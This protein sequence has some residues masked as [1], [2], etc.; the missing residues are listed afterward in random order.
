VKLV[1]TLVLTLTFDIV[2]F[3]SFTTDAWQGERLETPQFDCRMAARRSLIHASRSLHHFTWSNPNLPKALAPSRL[4]TSSDTTL[5][6]FPLIP[7][8]SD[9]IVASL[10]YATD[11]ELVDAI[12]ADSEP[13]APTTPSSR[14]RQPAR[15][16]SGRRY[17]SPYDLDWKSSID[18]AL[19]F[20][21]LRT[22]P[23][24]GR[25]IEHVRPRIKQIY[26]AL[27]PSG[28]HQLFASDVLIRSGDR[29]VVRDLLELDGKQPK[30]LRTSAI[31]SLYQHIQSDLAS[32]KLEALSGDANVAISKALM[33]EGNIDLVPGIWTEMCKTVEWS[34]SAS[35]DFFEIIL[36]MTRHDQLDE[37][38]KMVQKLVE[39]EVMPAAASAG[40]S[41]PNHPEARTLLVQTMITRA[42][43]EYGM[44]G[45]VQIAA[46]DLFATL[47]KSTVSPHAA[48]L[49]MQLC[50]A[51]VVGRRPDQVRWAG[52]FL[53]RFA[54]LSNAPPL[55]SS[56]INTFLQ[57]CSPHYGVDWYLSL[58]E[59]HEPPS[60]LH[61]ARMAHV[62]P[63]KVLLT[64][65]LKDVQKIPL[66]EFVGQR[67]HFIS[68]LILA[69]QREALVQLY[70][71]WEGSFDLTPKIL[72]RTVRLLTEGRTGKSQYDEFL[73]RIMRKYWKVAR[74][75]A[76]DSPLVALVLI[77]VYIMRRQ[78]HQIDRFELMDVLR[79]GKDDTEIKTYVES[80]IE[81]DP[82]E[83]YELVK[84][85][86]E[87]AGLELEMPVQAV[88]DT[89][90]SGHWDAAD[91]LSRI[92]DD[93]DPFENAQ[94]DP[95][96]QPQ[97][98]RLIAILRALKS[99]RPNAALGWLAKMHK[100]HDPVPVRLYRALVQR[101][102][103]KDQWTLAVT[104]WL[105]AYA[106]Y[107]A[108][109]KPADLVVLRQTADLILRKLS[110]CLE[111]AGPEAA[112]RAYQATQKAE[113]AE[114]G[115]KAMGLEI[116]SEEWGQFSKDEEIKARQEIRT[117]WE[118]TM[119]KVA[120][121]EEQS[122]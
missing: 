67:S 111:H 1:L 49:V 16:S 117:R 96:V 73:K 46:D 22:R 101:C 82:I 11:S 59:D 37:A 62:R 45:R 6:D 38:V 115:T 15:T 70:T 8:A 79:K 69:R 86:R 57:H 41:D 119:G 31:V 91:Q 102:M 2:Q 120:Q 13:A 24:F 118:M 122:L 108:D 17:V 34:I 25:F 5:D 74:R 55:S 81:D 52:K 33:A 77:Q 50:R 98:R 72:V 26:D 35:W 60:P 110:T 78:A 83:G 4:A 18:P 10:N 19:A 53:L 56:I 54:K 93:D 107:T 44:M 80:V 68:A 36:Y 47:A 114:F 27:Q 71:V 89:C 94:L 97:H 48:D 112:L 51:T 121:V 84:F 113:W 100:A 90:L 9:P 87:Q 43:L 7:T 23:I 109:G 105:Q 99:E 21:A 64:A 106:H 32:G 85:L 116:D 92:P 63:Q 3:S 75:D 30:H 61:I 88:I 103:L 42:L 95:S 29:Q 104:A 66:A 40:R 12:L 65:L 20:L 58:P 39:D 76:P 14:A 28:I